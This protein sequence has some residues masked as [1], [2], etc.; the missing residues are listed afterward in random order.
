MNQH[1]RILTAMSGGVD[2]SVTAVLLLEQGY[3]IAGATM[4]L[5]A[6]ESGTSDRPCGT[7][8]NIADARR[9][10]DALGIDFYQFDFTALFPPDVSQR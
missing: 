8:D 2:S 7:E 10:C 4:K 6:P 5:Y 3:S 9:V 1:N